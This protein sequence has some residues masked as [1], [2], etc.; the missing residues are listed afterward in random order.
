MK[1]THIRSSIRGRSTRWSRGTTLTDGIRTAQFT[2]DVCCQASNNV[3][4]WSIVFVGVCLCPASWMMSAWKYLR[5][6]CCWQVMLKASV[7]SEAYQMKC[8]TLVCKAESLISIQ[9]LSKTSFWMQELYRQSSFVDS[10]R[11][12][13]AEYGCG[14]NSTCCLWNVLAVTFHYTIILEPWRFFLLVCSNTPLKFSLQNQITCPSSHTQIFPP[15][16]KKESGQEDRTYSFRNTDS[17][18]PLL[19]QLRNLINNRPNFLWRKFFR[20]CEA[21]ESP[22]VRYS[23]DENRVFKD[24]CWSNWSRYE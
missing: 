11:S 4:C 21:C 14:Y 12:W 1:K 18:L 7:R 5:F 16:P 8:G 2:P 17:L 3:R 24:V 20:H 10:A 23:V 9:F 19:Q 15:P 6:E 22:E 13:C